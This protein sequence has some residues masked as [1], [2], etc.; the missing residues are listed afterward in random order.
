MKSQGDFRIQPGALFDD[1]RAVVLHGVCSKLGDGV[2][3][4][5][6]PKLNCCSSPCHKSKLGAAIQRWDEREASL[7]I[8]ELLGHHP[9]SWQVLWAGWSSPVFHLR[10][11]SH[12]VRVMQQEKRVPS[13]SDTVPPALHT[14][15]IPSAL[16]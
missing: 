3:E 11:E 10:H 6:G 4:A 14:C 9:Q 8:S 15:S 7:S 16:P 1:P 2:L 12:N 13:T 5:A